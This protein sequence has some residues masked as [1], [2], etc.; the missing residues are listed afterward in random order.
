[1]L[2][3]AGPWSVTDGDGQ[4]TAPMRLPG[5]VHT[6]LFA[7]GLIPDPYHG[8]NEYDLRW[9]ADR[10]WILSRSFEH[11]G[12]GPA[13]LVIDVLDTIG[14]IR[15]NGHE[16]LR[17]ASAFVPIA[18]DV[19][20]SLVPGENRI[21]IILRSSTRAADSL[22]ASQPFPVPY[23]AGNCPI[24]NGNML[25]KPQCD[26]GWDWNIALAPLGVYGS[27]GLAGPEGLIDEV[28]V[29]QTHAA[30]A[31]TLEIDVCLCGFAAGPVAWSV[32]ICG[33]EATGETEARGTFSLD[34]IRFTIEIQRSGGRPGTV[35]SRSTTSWSAPAASPA[36][37][38]SRSATSASS[39][40]PTPSAAASRSMST[41]ARSSPAAPTGS[42]P[43]P[44]PAGSPRSGPARSCSRPRTR[45]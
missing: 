29:R 33:Q 31:V 30:A 37:S 11:S 17:A 41:A 27:I 40:S 42:R 26:F 15:I 13:T 25:R 5:D 43:T 18:T 23:H 39:P 36:R 14:E 10:D 21:E 38:S 22:A 6:A 2:D 19:G 3:L 8:R 32:A 20:R 24:P 12:A 45:T 16:V 44:C 9:V 34:T 4:F 1:M 7:A 35:R 28:L